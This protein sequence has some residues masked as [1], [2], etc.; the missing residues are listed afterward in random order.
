[1]SKREFAK[2]HYGQ[3]NYY[4]SVLGKLRIIPG[5]YEELV[6]AGYRVYGQNL[7]ISCQQVFRKYLG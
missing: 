6:K 3:S 1:M 7:T 5:A 4:R 2:Y